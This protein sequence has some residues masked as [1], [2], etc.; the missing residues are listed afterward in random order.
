MYAQLTILLALSCVLRA[1]L[2]Q[3]MVVFRLSYR[4]DKAL[5][6]AIKTSDAK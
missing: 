4:R 6:Y 1:I 2:C 5:Y 3:T